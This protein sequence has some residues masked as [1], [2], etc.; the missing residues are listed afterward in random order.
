[1][2]MHIAAAASKLSILKPRVGACVVRAGKVLGVGYNRPG[3]SSRSK[4]KY[5]RHAEITALIAAG[6][7]RNS[8]VFVY[9]AHGKTGLPMLSKP[10]RDC[11]E[12]L[13]LAGVKKVV[14]SQ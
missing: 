1:M 10:C 2:A 12:A 5:S 3:S 8:T 9:R 6:D 13:E 7:A 4:S 11:A 14:W